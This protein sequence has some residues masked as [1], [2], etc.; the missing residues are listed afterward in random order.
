M[1]ISIY[2]QDYTGMFKT[3]ILFVCPAMLLAWIQSVDYSAYLKFQ[4][5]TSKPSKQEGKFLVCLVYGL[6]RPGGQISLV[7]P[8]RRCPAIIVADQNRPNSPLRRFSGGGK[9]QNPGCKHWL[10]CLLH[11]TIHPF[12]HTTITTNKYRER[13][14]EMYTY[15]YPAGNNMATEFSHL[16]IWS[17]N[18]W[19]PSSRVFASYQSQTNISQLSFEPSLLGVAATLSLSNLMALDD[20][21]PQEEAH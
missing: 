12:I 2:T 1:D 17:R 21:H 20:A 10:I 11:L 9:W 15:T 19:A 8:R 6:G 7:N 16:D 5:A 3:C 13:E 14:R 18:S 4:R